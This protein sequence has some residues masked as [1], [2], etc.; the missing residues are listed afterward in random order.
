MYIFSSP[1]SSC[2]YIHVFSDVSALKHVI[3]VGDL[4]LVKYLVEEQH[5]DPN[6]CVDE[7][8]R[9]PLHWASEHGYVS[10]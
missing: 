8:K 6:T 3:K 7:D 4:S 1:Y 2:V 10:T 5:V 9:T